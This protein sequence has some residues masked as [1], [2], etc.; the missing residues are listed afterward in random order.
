MTSSPRRPPDPPGLTILVSLHDVMPSTLSRVGEILSLLDRLDVRPVTLLVVPGAGWG[1][2]DLERLRELEDRGHPLAGHGW[3]HRAARVRGL[4][5]RLHAALLSRT[6][7]EHLALD[8]AEIARLIERCHGWFGE[9]GLGPPE[10]YV[11]PAWAMG[12]ISRKRL[13]RLPFRR[14]E[15]LGGVL[16][17]ATGRILRLP[18]AGF[19]AD[20]PARAAFLRLWNRLNRGLSSPRRPL[21]VAIHPG[22]LL[23]PLEASLRDLLRSSRTCLGYDELP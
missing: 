14:Y 15:L 11:P 8:A 4:R 23:L 21:R 3:R 9:H 13:A 12:T 20:T 1:D 10:L 6:V 5:H 22:D 7:A 18:L 19:E 16:D 2:D 17:A